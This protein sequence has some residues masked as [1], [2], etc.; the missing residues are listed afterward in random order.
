MSEYLN[1]SK[2]YKPFKYRDV[3]QIDFD[4]LHRRELEIAVKCSQIFDEHKVE[5]FNYRRYA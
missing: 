3:S 1:S 4:Y 5:H 2:R